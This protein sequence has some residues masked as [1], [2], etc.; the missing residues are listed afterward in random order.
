VNVEPNARSIAAHVITRVLRED[1]FAAPV[2][3]T[4]L[5]R[6]PELDPR[7]RA[8]ATEITYG[9]LRT[10]PYLLT[11]IGRHA[12]RGIG[13]IDTEVRAHLIVAAY[14]IL[15]LDRVPA[16][17]AVSE[18]VRLIRQARGQKVGAFANA[19]LR[20]ISEGAAEN[21]PEQL[22]RAIEQSVAPWLRDTLTRALG[23]TGAAAFLSA[24]APPPLCVRIRIGQ[25]RASAIDRLRQSAPSTASIEPGKA[26]P[27]AILIRGGGDPHRLTGYEQGQIVIQE[28]G[29]Q[30]VALALGA[31]SGE[32]VLDA[33]AG[34][35]NKTSL[36][37]EAVGEAGAVDAAD[38][39]E[40]KLDRLRGEL[41]KLGLSPRAT[42][43]VDWRVGRGGAKEG[44]DRVLVDAPCSG[45]GTLRRR[46]E[47][48]LRRESGDLEG[49]S[50]LQLRV[51]LATAPLVRPGGI[52]VYAVC[53]VLREE[54]EDVV[55]RA[56][57]EMPSLTPVK[58]PDGPARAIAGEQTAFRLLPH[59]HGTDGY[60]VACLQRR[61][62]A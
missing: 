30:F 13:T 39:H 19:V 14:Q 34:R 5:A 50:D 52:I 41:G 23:E 15:F 22:K 7:E 48:A 57:A 24:A 60:F 11:E 10:A 21:R 25:D 43:A 58:F 32:T 56:I 2:L 3:D 35:G 51:L 54:A 55:A 31:R 9:S 36:L 26:S 27:L 6:Y 46:P 8:L 33:C 37:A 40:Q 42:F 59:V 38:L 12:S 28:E 1:A 49:L 53:S 61:P 20:R 17:A 4:A 18:A 45:V 62:D 29:A 16:F 47:L 44:Y